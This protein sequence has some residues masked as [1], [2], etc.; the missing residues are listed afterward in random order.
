[1]AVIFSYLEKKTKAFNQIIS[2][3]EYLMDGLKRSGITIEIQEEEEEK[4]SLTF[5]RLQYHK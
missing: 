2:I 5:S 4:K 3:F 1:M